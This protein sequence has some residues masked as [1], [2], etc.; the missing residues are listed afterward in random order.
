M[1]ATRL[2]VGT[3]LVSAVLLAASLVLAPAGAAFADGDLLKDALTDY[4]AGR[5]EDALAKLQEYVAGNPEGEEVFAI[6]RAAENRVLLR[7]LAQGGDH[8]KYIKYLM[9]KARPVEAE[10]MADADAIRAAIE[11]AVNSADI[12][13]QRAAR[14]RLRSAGELAV[15]GLVPY[16]ASEDHGTLVNAMLALQ[17]IGD[18]ATVPLAEALEA[19]D[20]RI[21]LFAARTLGDLGDR[22]AVAA[23]ARVAAGDEDEGAKAAAAKA[24]ARL[25]GSKGSAADIYA[26]MGNRYYADEVSLVTAFDSVKNLWRWEDGAVARYTAPSYLYPYLMA[27]ECAADALAIDPAHAG[28]RSLLV[29]ALLAQRVEAEVLK[30]NGGEAPEALAGAFDLAKTQGFQAASDALATTLAQEDWEVAVECCYLMAAAYGGESLKGSPLGDALVAPHKRVRYAAAIS[31]LHMSPKRGLANADK[32]AALA[33]QAASESAVRQVLVIDDRDDTRAKLLI[34]L[35]QGGYVAA[36]DSSGT[37]GVIRA[38]NSPTL[39]VI[40]VR[41]DLGDPTNTV[42]SARHSSSLTVIDEIFADARTQEM[43]VVVLLDDTPE[44]RKARVQ[45]IYAAKY[46]DKVRFIETP[47][48]ESAVLATVTEAAEAGEL[49]PDRERANALAAKAAGA[50]ADMD[51]T[52]AT[53]NLQVA[54]EPLATAATTGPTPEIRLNAVRA[55]GNIKVGGADALVQVL[56]EGE[57]DEL[58]AAAARALGGVLSAQDATPEQVA[59]LMEAAKGEGDV[60]TAALAALG[61]VRNLDG[62]QRVELFRTHRLQV[63]EKAE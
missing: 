25:G 63:A 27:E 23:L 6:I 43:R 12:A 37:N 34:A 54:V 18:A 58:R 32:V 24:L 42:P 46:G 55:L 35:H 1:K 62:A 9:D 36:G 10:R 33:A 21:R 28:A 41:A 47:V 49:N 44:G 50:F 5:Y 56:T 14:A 29:R 16:L 48:V 20:A 31:A 45:E 60:A 53:F 61:Q 2:R 3:A 38:K 11:A 7:A 59:A 52:C 22:R 51:F 15:P 39:D 13:S 30:G 17:Q 57:G 19:E 8:E 40:I 4:G 26:R